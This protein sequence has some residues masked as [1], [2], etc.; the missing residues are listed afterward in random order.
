VSTDLL[1]DD[2]RSH[3][4]IRALHPAADPGNKQFDGVLRPS[5]P[6][7]RTHQSQGD[8]LRAKHQRLVLGN[9]SP[10]NSVVLAAT[11]PVSE[12]SLLSASRQVVVLLAAPPATDVRSLGATAGGSPGI[13]DNAAT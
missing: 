12:S 10:I 8:E 13:D 4:S 7:H 9:W 1:P 5:L 2:R 3:G 6:V 11:N